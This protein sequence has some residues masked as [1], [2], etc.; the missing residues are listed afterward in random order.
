M[1]RSELGTLSR[2][3]PKR[4]RQAYRMQSDQDLQLQ[5]PLASRQRRQED[6]RQA[7]FVYYNNKMSTAA[8]ILNSL[9]SP[10]FCSQSNKRQTKE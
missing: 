4:Y 7:H 5:S 10:T 6:I 3:S 8:D 2:T 1:A 9:E